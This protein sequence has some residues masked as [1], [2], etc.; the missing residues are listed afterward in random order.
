MSWLHI[1]KLVLY[2][3]EN[4]EGVEYCG[5]TRASWDS[6]W[7]VHVPWWVE[8][9]LQHQICTVCQ[10]P[11]DKNCKV[12][13]GLGFQPIAARTVC[14]LNDHH[15]HSLSHHFLR[16]PVN[17]PPELLTILSL[18][19]WKHFWWCFLMLQRRQLLSLPSK[20]QV[21][22]TLRKSWYFNPIAVSDTRVGI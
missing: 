11:R 10:G 2:K 4:G 6:G 14:Q 1:F 18:F 21:T 20:G 15:F 8:S 3:L 9:S 5:P 16:G 22:R 17:I 19:F 13:Q 7:G 12:W